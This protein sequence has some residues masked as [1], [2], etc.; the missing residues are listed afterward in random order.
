[1]KK[2]SNWVRKGSIPMVLIVVICLGIFAGASLFMSGNTAKLDKRAELNLMAWTIGQSA[3]EEALVK[4][5]NGKAAASEGIRK[6]VEPEVTRFTY[7]KN[8]NVTVSSVQMMARTVEKPNIP[9][10]LV[11]F[12]RTLSAGPGFYKAGTSTGNPMFA[13]EAAIFA[14]DDN[15]TKTASLNGS[16]P[17]ADKIGLWRAA[18][19]ARLTNPA[20]TADPKLLA[21]EQFFFKLAMA[22]PQGDPNAIGKDIEAAY[23][24]ANEENKKKYNDEQKTDASANPGPLGGVEKA[25]QALKGITPA[26][27]GTVNPALTTFKTQWDAAMAEVLNQVQSRIANCAGNPNYGIGAETGALMVGKAL[28]AD[29]EAEEHLRNTAQNGGALDYTASLVSLETQVD[30]NIAGVKVSQPYSV[31]RMVQKV[32]FESAMVFMDKQIMAYL[33]FYYGLNQADFASVGWATAA[34]PSQVPNFDLLTKLNAGFPASPSPKVW[35]FAIATCL[36]KAK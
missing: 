33:H 22:S 2:S 20:V 8:P 13:N 19:K 5:S 21:E 9:T 32:N 24:G 31:Q 11:E 30:V 18:L 3:V 15:P 6:L 16:F 28:T 1:M 29:G 4:Y 35:P 12:Y 23:S 27:V 34:D 25:F 10:D 7:A 26:A 36:G 17:G 14:Q